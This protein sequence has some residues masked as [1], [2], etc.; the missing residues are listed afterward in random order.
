MDP[1]ADLGLRRER[2]EDLLREAEQRRLA[3]ELREARRAKRIEVR[4]SLTGA[5]H[6]IVALL[7]LNGRPRWESFEE[8][9][10]VA[11]EKGKDTVGSPVPN[12]LQADL[13]EA[14]HHRPLG[15]GASP[16]RGPIPRIR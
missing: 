5:E 10:I 8:R 1:Q 2:R 13:D 9:L 4:W 6:K 16:G 3:R 7:E 11:E 12:D 15:R 14:T